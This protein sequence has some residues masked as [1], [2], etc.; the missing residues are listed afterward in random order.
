MVC[1]HEDFILLL[2]NEKVYDIYYL[3]IKLWMHDLQ[4]SNKF[5]IN[6]K[7]KKIEVTACLGKVN[8]ISITYEQISV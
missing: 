6:K 3:I 4:N 7:E 5:L 2:M 8:V 1:F